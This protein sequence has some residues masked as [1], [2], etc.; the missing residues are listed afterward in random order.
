MKTSDVRLYVKSVKTV[1]EIHQEEIPE[2]Y[3][4]P[5]LQ[6]TFHVEV[7]E[8]TELYIIPEDQQKTLEMIKNIASNNGLK[9]E[10]IDLGPENIL[11]R[12]IEE[13]RKKIKTFPTLMADSGEKIEGEITEEQAKTFLTKIADKTRKKHP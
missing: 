4:S 7:T 10:V 11:H 2:Y 1:T 5:D 3:A 6:E 12:A 13:E 8:P 9:V